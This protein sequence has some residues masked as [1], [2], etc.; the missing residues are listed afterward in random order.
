MSSTET[1]K[2]QSLAIPDKDSTAI[3]IVSKL[4]S[5][6]QPTT[7]MHTKPKK[8]SSPKKATVPSSVTPSLKDSKRNTLD[9]QVLDLTILKKIYSAEAKDLILWLF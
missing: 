9:C 1:I 4:I 6:D 7:K 5:L 2:I 3:T 8:K